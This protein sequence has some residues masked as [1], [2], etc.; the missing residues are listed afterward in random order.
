MFNVTR[1]KDAP[2]SLAGKKEYGG[3]D[4][5]EALEKIFYGKCYLCEIKEPVSLNVEHFV[6]HQGDEDKKFDWNNLY[7]VCGRCNNVKLTKYD[8]LIDCTDPNVDVFRAIKHLPPYSPRGPIVVQAEIPGVKAASTAELLDEIFN[9]AEKSIN[10]QI[11]GVYLR[12]KIFK[13]FNRFLKQINIYIDEESPPVVKDLAFEVMKTMV[14]KNQEFSAF[15]RWVVLE[16]EL[17]S[18]L[19][20]AEMD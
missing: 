3:K 4:V 7:Y 9:A 20:L 12:T 16:D 5:L 1:P 13:K 18:S 10:K 15:I 17:L 14:K 19:L 8:D 11:T 2:A 6:S